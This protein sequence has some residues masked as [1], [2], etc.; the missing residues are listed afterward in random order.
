MYVVIH[1]M[2][3]ICDCLEMVSLDDFFLESL[4]LWCLPLC[5]FCPTGSRYASICML[6]CIDVRPRII[7][8]WVPWYNPNVYYNRYDNGMFYGLLGL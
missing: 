2:D 6:E 5:G 3:K 1:S 4:S 8:L 7:F